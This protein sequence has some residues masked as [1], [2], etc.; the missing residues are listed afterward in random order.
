MKHKARVLEIL[1]E[2][3]GLAV[4]DVKQDGTLAD[5]GLDSLDAVEL[6]VAL[7][8]DFGIEIPDTDAAKFTTVQDVIS[9]INEHAN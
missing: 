1:A 7:E 3:A 6:V 8:E 9:Y 2:L 4:S 5:N